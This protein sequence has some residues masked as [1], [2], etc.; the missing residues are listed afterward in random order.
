MGRVKS[1]REAMSGL[2]ETRITAW[3]FSL[4]SW[5]SMS[6]TMPAFLTS[7]L[8]VG[9]SARMIVGWL[10]GD[11]HPLLLP[12]GK[13]RPQAVHLVAQA[14]GF[15]EARRA[16]LHL[17]R[18]E[19][20]QLSHGHHDVLEHGELEHQEV[21]L[22]DE[23]DVLAA[24]RRADRVLAVRHQLVVD[25]DLPRVR[26]VE[27]AQEVE[28]RRFSASRR[29]HDGVDLSRPGLERDPLE[30]MDPALIPS[31][32]AVQLLAAE[33]DFGF[34]GHGSAYW[35]VP[36]MMSPGSSLAARRE[37]MRLASMTMTTAVD[38]AST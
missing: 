36:R 30:D 38:T 19:P 20:A 34:L 25:P 14:H 4:A 3:P 17:L 8:P 31:Q 22:E 33:G 28:E 12:A 24:G 7:R 23:P 35:A 15:Q 16:L 11:R 2:C 6:N 5:V 37:G 1:H 27:E 29:P 32:E 21:E 10:A 26:E 13:V 18:R 9:S